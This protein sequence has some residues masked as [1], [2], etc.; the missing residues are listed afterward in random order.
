M[1][2]LLHGRDGGDDVRDDAH[3]SRMYN[4]LHGRDGGDDVRD[5][6]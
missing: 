6:V 3:H 4:L 2:N 1:Y 5:P